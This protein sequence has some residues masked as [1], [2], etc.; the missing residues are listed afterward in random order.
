MKSNLK[1]K[2]VLIYTQVFSKE[3]YY[4]GAYEY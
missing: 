4:R 3:Q 1:Q 2:G